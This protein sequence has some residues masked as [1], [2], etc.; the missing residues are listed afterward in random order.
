VTGALVSDA[1][2]TAGAAD[3]HYV[4][5]LDELSRA[6][7]ESLEEGDVLLAMGAGDIDE[8]A[9]DLT[10]ALARGSA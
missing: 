4:E 7:R 10:D 9:H 5:T 1:A 3:V 2:R 8:M 6:L